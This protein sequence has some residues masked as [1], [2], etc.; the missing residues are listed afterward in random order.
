MPFPNESQSKALEELTKFIKNS[1]DK[2]YVLQG[3][4]G[5]GKTS[6]INY[7]FT[8][9]YFINKTV[10][11]SAP[12]NKAVSVMK[13][14]APENSSKKSMDYKTIHKLFSMKRNIDI[15][16]N[17]Q[18][19][20]DIDALM[21]ENYIERKNKYKNIFDYDFI[22]IDECSMISKEILMVISKYSNKIKGKIIF[23]GDMCQ[24]PPINEEKSKVFTIVP[25]CNLS[26]VVRCNSKLLP[27]CN[28]IRECIETNCNGLKIKQ[29]K[30]DK[31]IVIRNKKDWLLEYINLIKTDS[32]THQLSG[33]DSNLNAAS[34]NPIILAYTNYCVNNI[35]K[36]IRKVLYPTLN[37]LKYNENERI[38]FNSYYAYNTYYYYTSQTQII[39]S[40]MNDEITLK[41]LKIKD[42]L[43]LNTAITTS[44]ISY[45]TT[46]EPTQ[47]FS[48]P[49]PICYSDNINTL[50][51]TV[52]GH[53][54]CDECIKTW[55]K[56]NKCCPMCRMKIVNKTEISISK[57]D[58]VSKYVNEFIAT[59]KNVSLDIYRIKLK[60]T[61]EE[62]TKPEQKYIL[63]VRNEENYKL[64]IEKLKGILGKIRDLIKNKKV[65]NVK[66]VCSLLKRLWEY[67]YTIYYDQFAQL[68]YGYCITSHKS[69]G[70]TYSTVFI[71][72]GNILNSNNKDS[73][74]CLYTSITRAA[75]SLTIYY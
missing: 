26:D 38:V 45:K 31:L 33:F 11:F 18:F 5:T 56:E 47:E 41:E 53:K 62:L 14:M 67:T 69:Q 17:S 34:S 51:K 58:I 49:C 63:V 6:L 55:L 2:M 59:T 10:V 40:L 36:E 57:H 16:G 25:C 32:K 50:Y 64:V 15:N 20:V 8:G 42:L 48:E 52:C 65:T 74:K 35:N 22:V 3:H 1:K 75:D 60:K 72:A 43:D 24:L 61:V 27:F 44:N 73:L 23:L 37:H 46:L 66:L 71:E 13:S 4:A 29:F 39:D 68:N 12:T 28:Y 30:N 9:S 19:N 21:S 7:L 70:S 54:F